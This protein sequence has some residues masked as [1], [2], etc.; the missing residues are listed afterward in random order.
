MRRT[1]G[2]VARGNVAY[3]RLAL[4]A[5]GHPGRSFLLWGHPAQSATAPGRFVPVRAAGVREGPHFYPVGAGRYCTP[6]WGYKA[7][8][9]ARTL[10]AARI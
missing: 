5:S 10:P 9:K 2:V 8:L 6:R 3:G 7:T 1:L 4:F